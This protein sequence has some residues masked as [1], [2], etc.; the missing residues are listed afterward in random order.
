VVG[1]ES[2]FSMM[3]HDDLERLVLDT[4]GNPDYQPVKPRVLA[5]QLNLPSDARRELKKAVKSLVKKGKL[6]YGSS[7]L[8]RLAT[9]NV[10]SDAVGIFH[11]AAGGFGFVRLRDAQEGTDQLAD[12]YIPARKTLDA[13]TGDLVRVRMGRRPGVKGA[14]RPGVKGERRTGQIVEVIERETHQFVGTYFEQAG[15][16]YVQI[17]GTLFAKPILVGDARAKRAQPH[18]KVVIEMVRFPSH[19]HWGEGVITEVLGDRGA[20]GVDTMLVVRE[21][22]LPQAFADD[23]LGAARR[24]ADRFD[25]TIGKGRLDL[26]HLAVVTIDPVDARDFDDAI[27]LEQIDNDHWRLGV[28]IADVAHFV[29]PKTPLDREAR[30]RATSVYLPDR[31]IPMLPEIISNNLASLQPDQVRYVMTA[32]LELTGDGTR[33]ST[34]LCS[35]AIK[36]RRRF[37]YEEVDDFLADRG[38]WKKKL[39]PDVHRLLSDMHRL[40]VILRGRRIERGA[41]DLALPEVKLDIDRRGRVRGAF[42]VERTES[43]QIIEEFMLAANE[44]VAEYLRDRK[45][46]FLRRIHESPDPVKLKALSEFVRELKVPSGSLTS[47]FE[48]QRLLAKVVNSPLQDA[49]NY[50]VLRSMQKAIYSPR[51][52][53]HYALASDCYCHFTSP[54]RRYPDLTVHRMID[55][56]VRG[57]RPVG[58]LGTLVALAEHCSQRQQRA[59]AA[60]RELTK[61]KLLGYLSTRIG[62]AMD[63]VVTGVESFGLFVQGIPLPAEGLIHVTSLMDDYYDYDKTT[64]TLAG[65]RA[66]NSYRLGDALRVEIAHVDLDRR[67]LDFR[68]ISKLA[69][70]GGTKPSPH[71]TGRRAAV[72]KRRA[73]AGRNAR[74]QPKKNAAK[75]K[76]TRRTRRQRRD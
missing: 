48:I 35:A 40:A 47:R 61:L 3:N 68:L 73:R 76:K 23:A 24:E 5:K 63:A 58:E 12:V 29:R 27:S 57:R 8:V 46:H 7:H 28:H 49:V 75:K 45:L 31:V 20:P 59:E 10:R 38:K 55:S 65:R 36:S 4:V 70:G 14:R 50:A 25:G 54:I 64:H 17:D 32:F 33:V 44:A 67:E 74:P 18:D 34:E 6:A 37:T 2:M 9:T 13:S 16:G 30:E 42:R 11:R 41:I 1:I 69:P 26:T 19:A 52:V 39:K 56:L 62:Q 53:G 22:D 72:P 66:G 21:F 51:D 43:H 71:V 15:A 60:E